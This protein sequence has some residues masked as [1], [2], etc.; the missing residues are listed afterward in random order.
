[1]ATRDLELQNRI[2]KSPRLRRGLHLPANSFPQAFK[3]TGV[4]QQRPR[5]GSR[6]E[7]DPTLRHAQRFNKTRKPEDMIGKLALHQGRCSGPAEGW[8]KVAQKRSPK[9]QKP[10][11]QA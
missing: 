3:I 2:L 7:K 6:T 5:R 10:R 8:S 9:E 1:M 4:V 11:R